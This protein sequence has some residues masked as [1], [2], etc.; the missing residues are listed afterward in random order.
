MNADRIL[1][2]HDGRIVDF[3]AHADLVHRPGIYHDLYQEQFKTV[4]GLSDS[5]RAKLLI[6][7]GR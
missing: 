5:E 3:G 7:A 1:V 4:G 6:A 2:M